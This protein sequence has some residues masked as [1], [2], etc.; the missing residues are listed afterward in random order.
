MRASLVGVVLAAVSCARTTAQI[1]MP[2]L[3]PFS[4]RASVWL[5]FTDDGLPMP[6][7]NRQSKQQAIAAAMAAAQFNA[8]NGSIVKEFSQLPPWCKNGW[9]V[10]KAFCSGEKQ[11]RYWY[12]DTQAIRCPRQGKKV[13]SVAMMIGV[14][15]LFFLINEI[16]PNF[17]VLGVVLMS[18]QDLGIVTLYFFDWSER[19]SNYFF[20]FRVAL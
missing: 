19:L 3:N 20:V 17:P 18:Y 14:L 16:R 15:V 5:P 9:D 6:T 10:T 11:G 7:L 1:G 8:R 2:P 12:L 13:F 4:H